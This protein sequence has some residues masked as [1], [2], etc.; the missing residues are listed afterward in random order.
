MDTPAMTPADLPPTG[1]T[2]QTLRNVIA[3]KEG[4]GEGVPKKKH[5][6]NLLMKMIVM[7]LQPMSIVEDRGFRRFLHGLDPKYVMPS[8]RDI[9]RKH[10]PELYEMAVKQLRDNMREP[11]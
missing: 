7:D 3:R 9:T 1:P 8:R 5:L 6:D 2:Q 4:Y 11:T 10:I